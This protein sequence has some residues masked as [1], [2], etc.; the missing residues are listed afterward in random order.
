MR[1]VIGTTPLHDAFNR[2]PFAQQARERDRATWFVF[3]V[4]RSRKPFGSDSLV[5]LLSAIVVLLQWTPKL[6]IYER[7]A[8]RGRGVALSARFCGWADCPR[9]VGSSLAAGDE[10]R[11]NRDH[12]R[13]AHGNAV[14]AALKRREAH[15]S[16]NAALAEARRPHGGKIFVGD[17]IGMPGNFVD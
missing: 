11:R 17:P 8:P 6:T 2:L 9:V 12:Y 3:N 14:L 5:E 16:Q 10:S 7:K 13:C 1:P 4:K 15:R